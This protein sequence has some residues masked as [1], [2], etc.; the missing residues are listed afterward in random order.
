MLVLGIPLRR[1]F[2]EAINGAT[3]DLLEVRHAVPTESEMSW[4]QKTLIGDNQ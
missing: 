2:G 1:L 4:F 3:E